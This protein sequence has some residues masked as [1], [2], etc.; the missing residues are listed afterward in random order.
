VNK[1]FCSEKR[2]KIA[3][4]S[5]FLG[6]GQKNEFEKFCSTF[7][8]T[9]LNARKVVTKVGWTFFVTPKHGRLTEKTAHS[10]GKISFETLSCT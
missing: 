4:T 7:K 10:D 6:R 9:E 8:K 5:F 3:G 1:K 2:R